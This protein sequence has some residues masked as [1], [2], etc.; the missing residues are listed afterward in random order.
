M[1][2]NSINTF[3]FIFIMMKALVLKGTVTSGILS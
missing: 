2:V 1:S 3:V